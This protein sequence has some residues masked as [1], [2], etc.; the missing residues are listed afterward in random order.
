M[1]EKIDKI[2]TRIRQRLGP[3]M[4]IFPLLST[5]W[6]ITSGITVSRD[7]NKSGYLLGYLAALVLLSVLM[8]FWLDRRAFTGTEAP[9]LPAPPQSRKAR[10]A[11]SLR[12]NPKLIE[13]PTLQATQYCAQYIVTFSLPLLFTARAWLTLGLVTALA[14]TTLWDKWWNALCQRAWYRSVIR[15]VSTVLAVSFVF[16]VFFP[17]DLSWFHPV[18]AALALASVL[19]WDVLS[20]Q[21]RIVS[22]DLAPVTFLAAMIL[23]QVAIGPAAWFPLLSVWIKAPAM[24]FG[25]DHRILSERMDSPVTN[26]R[27][28]AA[29]TSPS[30]LCCFTPVKGP[31]GISSPLVHEWRVNG[32]LVDTIHLPP[33]HG[34]GTHPTEFRTYSC[35]RFFP[36]REKI[37]TI[38]CLAFLEGHHLLSEVEIA[39]EERAKSHAPEDPPERL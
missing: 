20:R 11:T 34:T 10:I 6:G 23:L 29:L 35:K 2:R 37:R 13:I 30:G 31:L 21:R 25:M 39:V 32:H 8:R 28:E 1:Y 15:L 14:A 16:P 18:L 38:S 7:Y 12:K 36:Q 5:A 19:P 33:V 3:W 26:T 27:L 17:R 22:K 9:Q 24:G 4:I